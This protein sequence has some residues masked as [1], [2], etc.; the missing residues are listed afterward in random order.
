MKS[1]SHAA[2]S[3]SIS[4][5]GNNP[6]TAAPATGKTKRPLGTD[7]DATTTK[8]PVPKSTKEAEH[9]RQTAGTAPGGGSTQQI[10][11]A[12]T[13]AGGMESPTKQTNSGQ[14]ASE[15]RHHRTRSKNHHKRGPAQLQTLNHKATQPKRSPRTSGP[16]ASDTGRRRCKVQDTTHP[17]RC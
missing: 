10:K 3:C 9:H 16:Q 7:Q 12:L 1:A 2:R 8:W 14:T 13:G 17:E 6:A 15:L 4:S 11:L 5:P